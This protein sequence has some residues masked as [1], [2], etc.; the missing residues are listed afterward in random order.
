[1]ASI[2]EILDFLFR[3]DI[4]F[5]KNSIFTKV[6]VREKM[7]KLLLLIVSDDLNIKY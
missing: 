5:K 3:L 4:D 7:Y 2:L 1:M 6:S